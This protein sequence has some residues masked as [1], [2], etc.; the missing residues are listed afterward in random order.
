MAALLGGGRFRSATSC[1]HLREHWYFNVAAGL[2]T[3]AMEDT[4]AYVLLG[5][6]DGAEAPVVEVRPYD[7]PAPAEIMA[8]A[9]LAAHPACV[10]VEVW[11]GKVMLTA[12]NR[13]R[14]ADPTEG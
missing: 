13:T 10:R 6:E 12:Q 14:A 2:L 3:G 11:R 7:F 5:L 9:F 1:P 8:E 4:S